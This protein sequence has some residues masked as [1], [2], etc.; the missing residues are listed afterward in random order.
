MAPTTLT[1]EELSERWKVPLA[2]LNRWR[3]TGTGPEF[4]KLG[5]H[6]VYRIRDVEKFEEQKVRRDTT[7]IGFIESIEKGIIKRGV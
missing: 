1:P 2:T 3:W 6:I 5:K 4:M 7:C